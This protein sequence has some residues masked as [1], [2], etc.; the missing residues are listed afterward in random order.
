M[1]ITERLKSVVIASDRERYFFWNSL[2]PGY[3]EMS[4]NARKKKRARI[5]NLFDTT[6]GK[7]FEQYSQGCISKRDV[8]KA[9]YIVNSPK[10][11]EVERRMR[12]LQNENQEW[13]V[14]DMCKDVEYIFSCTSP[15]PTKEEEEDTMVTETQIQ[16]NYL[17]NRADTI[18]QDKLEDL[19]A[20]FHLNDNYPTSLKDAIQRLRDGKFKLPP[21]E[22]IYSRE[23]IHGTYFSWDGL[24]RSITWQLE[25]PNKEGFETAHAKLQKASNDLFDTIE[26]ADPAVA[27]A[28]MK[29][30]EDT[31]FSV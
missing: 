24:I 6:P 9:M 27:L 23:Y 12:F 26:I 29:E 2:V 13:F 1:D 3:S 4:S 18:H 11:E 30:F 7:L 10:E 17:R 19:R 5:A 31:D 21:D 28:K 15:N 20:K 8:L 25:E 14:E 16:R 22:Q